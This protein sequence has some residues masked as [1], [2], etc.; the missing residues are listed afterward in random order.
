MVSVYFNGLPID[1]PRRCTKKLTVLGYANPTVRSRVK[2]KS[3]FSEDFSKDRETGASIA[4]TR[5]GSRRKPPMDEATLSHSPLRATQIALT[6]VTSYARLL[7]SMPALAKKMKADLV[8]SLELLQV[9]LP[10]SF[11]SLICK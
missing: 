7:V 2:N 9:S 11:N 5:R 4:P 8:R 6:V 3:F 1:D 10:H